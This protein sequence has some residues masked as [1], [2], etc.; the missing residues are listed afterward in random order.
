L[1]TKI[2]HLQLLIWFAV[3]LCQLIVGL[4][5][6]RRRN[7]ALAIYLGIVVARFLWLFPVARLGSAHA[8]YIAYWI[9]AFV[10]YAAQVYLVAAIFQ[11]IRKTGIPD[12]NPLLL[13]VFAGCM[14]AL[15]ILTLRF[16]LTS[17]V[18][19]GWKWFLAIDHVAMYWL[20]LMLAV[21]PLYAWMVDSAKDTR[22][23]LIYIGFS[24]Y[25]AVRSGAVD[26][27]IGTHRAVHLTHFTE[28]AYLIS[29][30]LWLLSS[31]YPVASHQWDPAQTEF[32]KTALRAR[33]RSHHLHELSRYERSQKS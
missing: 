3:V 29:L 23:L 27:A 16:P 25:L 17:N 10:D 2:T 9:G 13:H 15:A 28:F 5:A 32:L 7:T 12:R 14:F 4:W 26:I 6:Y 21:V 31:N 20:C 22:L 1:H 24:L 8:Y 33:M 19:P 18:S 11:A 30:V